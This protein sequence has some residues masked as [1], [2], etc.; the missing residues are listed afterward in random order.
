MRPFYE[1]Q[2]NDNHQLVDLKLKSSSNLLLKSRIR[3]IL[4]DVKVKKELRDKAA[5]SATPTTTTV[6]NH[7]DDGILAVFQRYFKYSDYRIVFI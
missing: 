7:Q 2:Q 3:D 6:S 4:Y 1:L 5:L